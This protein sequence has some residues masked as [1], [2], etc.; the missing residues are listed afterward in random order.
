MITI[1][2]HAHLGDSAVSKLSVTPDDLLGAMDLYGIDVSVVLPHPVMEDYQQAHDNIAAL[3]ADYPTRIFGV[4]SLSP[5]VGIEI[6]RKEVTRCVQELGFVAVKYHPVLQS[7]LPTSSVTKTLFE[8][9]RSLENPVIV[10]TGL[11]MPWAHPSRLTP[12]A[13][14]YP[15]VKVVF[16]HSG[17]THFSLDALYAA[18]ECSNIYLETSWTAPDAIAHFIKEIGSQRV[19]MGADGLLNIPVELKK[20]E[21]LEL[22]EQD[23]AWCLGQTAINVFG[24]HVD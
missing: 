22:P 20:Y 9:A 2:A 15:D 1:D 8:I 10:H 14:N 12:L 7:A 21:V 19:M 4:A 23:L 24:L 5:Q 13:W 17:F 18:Q 11:G 16:A 3:A 6:Y